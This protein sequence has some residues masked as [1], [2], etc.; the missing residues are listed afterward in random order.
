MADLGTVLACDAV[1]GGGVFAWHA[2][3]PRFESQ[4]LVDQA[5]QHLPLV[6][7]RGGDRHKDGKYRVIPSYIWGLSLAWAM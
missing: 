5:W 4:K 2:Q 6:P 7:T 1:W 3:R